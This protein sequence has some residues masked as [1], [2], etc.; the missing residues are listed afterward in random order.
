MNEKVKLDRGSILWRIAEKFNFA[1]DKIIPDS[2]VF[3]LILT[4]IAYVLALILTDNG[5]IQ[6]IQHWYDGMWTQVALAFQISFTTVVCGATARAPQVK[7]VMYKLAGLV[8]TRVGAMLLIMLFSYLSTFLNWIFATVGGAILCMYLSKK[9]EDLHFP[10]AVAASYCAMI[11]ALCMTPSGVLYATVA[12]PGHSWEAEIGVLSQDV[13][14]YNPF[15]VITWFASAIGIL[16]LVLATRP[17]KDK[18]VRYTGEIGDDVVEEEESKVTI[19]DKMNGSRILMYILGVGIFVILGYQIATK[20]VFGALTLYFLIAL[21]MGFNCFL[22]PSPKKFMKALYGSIN[23][24]VEIMVGFPFYGGIMGIVQY[25]GLGGVIAAAIATITT[26]TTMP[27]VTYISASIL[28]LFIPSQGGQFIVQG[29]IMLEVCKQVGGN[30]V[31]L[32]NAFTYGDEATNLLQPLYCIPAMSA[33]GLKLKDIWGF[34]AFMWF[35]WFLITII[36]MSVLSG[37]L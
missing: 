1:A 36:S 20:G 16:V 19:A 37:I 5:P 7:K 15:N 8:H 13:T 27:I 22:Y 30:P 21:F 3:C 32:L 17:P 11:I 33:V 18:I 26:A 6:L 4:F 9:V 35:A 23:M 24:A 29:P 2:L 34:M 31:H 12:T 10:M 25:S 14:V 28:N